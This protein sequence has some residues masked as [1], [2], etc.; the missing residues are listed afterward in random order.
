MSMSTEPRAVASPDVVEG[1]QLV[2]GGGGADGSNVAG[3]SKLTILA[4]AASK[5]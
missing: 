1:A 3:S 5:F 4:A 2:Y